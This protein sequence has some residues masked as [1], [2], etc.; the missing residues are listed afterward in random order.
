MPVDG[1]S[2]DI[3]PDADLLG[4]AQAALADP[5]IRQIAVAVSGGGD[6]IALLHLL[7]RAC[8][9]TKVILHAVTVDHGLRPESASEAAGV[10]AFCASLGIAHTTL[11]W[12]DH[13][14]TGNLMDEARHA[15]RRLISDWAVASG[16]SHIA[17]GHTA[18]DQAETF[19]MGLARASGLDGLAGMRSVWTGDG[20]IWQR[21][22]LRHSRAEL[23]AYLMRHRILWVDDP[24]NN[25]D[26]FTRIKA[27]KA[28]T[29]LAPL[30]IT[31]KSL[32]TSIRHL[33]DAR[34]ALQQGLAMVAQNCVSTPGGAVCIGQVQFAALPADTQRRLL[35]LA[36]AW[37]SSAPYPPRSAKQITLLQ[38]GLA[39]RDATLNGCRLR[40]A[41]GQITLTREP[42]AVGLTQTPTRHLWDS[43]WRVDGPHA[44][45]LTLRALGAAGLRACKTWRDCG[46]SRDA[47]LVSPS[48]WRGD[49]LISAPLAGLN[50]EWTASIPVGF[51]KFILSH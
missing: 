47:L 21:P 6:S 14:P 25:D 37:L 29:A 8:G 16:I 7:H 18:D 33:N 23:R 19:L 43:R 24:S 44:A 27:R 38:A 45:D 26:R 13:S 48:V 10:A 30:G 41:A 1:S 20:V 46:I 40:H 50:P 2:R 11:Q 3:G 17:V 35:V 22:L 42:R 15:R 4:A 34:Q 9:Q 36:I 31:V 5:A 32:T 39:G 28:M 51:D 12:R 49:A